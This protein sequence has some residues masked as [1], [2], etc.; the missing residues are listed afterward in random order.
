MARRHRLSIRLSSKCRIFGADHESYLWG[1][2]AIICACLL[3]A[4]FNRDGWDL[5]PGAIS[6]IGGIPVH[7]Y[8]PGEIT[9]PAEIWI[10]GVSPNKCW[11]VA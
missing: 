1:N 7:A 5:R 10:T 9:P 4:S 3:G 2:P 6:R 8:A 11:I